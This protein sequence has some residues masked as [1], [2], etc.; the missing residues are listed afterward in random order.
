MIVSIKRQHTDTVV[1]R[2][3]THHPAGEAYP[4][5]AVLGTKD[6]VGSTLA[7]QFT[8]GN[9]GDFAG[10]GIYLFDAVGTVIKQCPYIPFPVGNHLVD[11]HAG[12]AVVDGISLLRHVES[13]GRTHE[14]FLIY[15]ENT[16]ETGSYPKLSVKVFKK[17]IR[18]IGVV[19]A[20]AVHY[21]IMYKLAFRRVV[22]A[23]AAI[24]S[25]PELSFTV[26]VKMAYPVV[27]QRIFP[28]SHLI[29]GN[30][31]FPIHKSGEANEAV[32]AA[33]PISSVRIAQHGIELV[34][35]PCSGNL[36]D[37]DVTQHTVMA[38]HGDAV[39][40]AEP[41]VMLTVGKDGP[42]DIVR[43]G[44]EV[45]G[46]MNNVQQGFVLL[47]DVQ[48]IIGAYQQ[49]PVSVQCQ[50]LDRVIMESIYPLRMPVGRGVF[51]KTSFCA[52]PDATACGIFQK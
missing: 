30:V 37:R 8:G 22:T 24:R 29:P 52:Y 14:V 47:I 27:G 28:V 13:A 5:V 49:L 42:D 25:H 11:E 32:G 39:I 12:Q 7:F 18:P 3:H 44:L 4:D 35:L 36:R 2:G 50:R 31:L 21:V 19:A 38:G 17:A 34:A 48:T 43:K 16:A 10:T 15:N 6:K 9:M 23:D 51:E 46:V 40:R 26:F 45:S 20:G 1:L 41:D 33:K